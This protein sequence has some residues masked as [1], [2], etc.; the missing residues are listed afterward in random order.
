MYLLPSELQF[1]FRH[2]QIR[3]DHC[4]SLKTVK[5]G[6]YCLV[7]VNNECFVCLIL[8]VHLTSRQEL[9]TLVVYRTCLKLVYQNSDEAWTCFQSLSRVSSRFLT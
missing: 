2:M 8:T 1:A 9:F 3:T 4:Y 7:R 5:I 6:L